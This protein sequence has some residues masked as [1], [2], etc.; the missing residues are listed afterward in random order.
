MKTHTLFCSL[1]IICMFA[2]LALAQRHSN[3]SDRSDRSDRRDHSTT[4]SEGGRDADKSSDRD[5]GKLEDNLKHAGLGVTLWEDNE[6]R[7]LISHVAPGSP[8]ARA[9]LQTGD[10]LLRFDDERIDSASEFIDDIRDKDPGAKIDL[11]I[12]RNGR[13][14]DVQAKLVAR[15]EAF[16]NVRNR[17]FAEDDSRGE[18]DQPIQDWSTSGGLEGAVQELQRQVTQLRREVDQLRRQQGSQRYST[19]YRGLPAGEQMP[20]R[21]YVP[22]YGGGWGGVGNMNSQDRNW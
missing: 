5:Q 6:G 2:G 12:R 17:T 7:V 1:G 4:R 20:A 19:G 14:Q 3:S 15:D 10:E 9:G 18:Y 11:T 16:R 8:A 22:S 13:K 21:I